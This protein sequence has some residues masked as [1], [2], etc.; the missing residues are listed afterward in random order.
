MVVTLQGDWAMLGLEMTAGSLHLLQDDDNRD[1]FRFILFTT[2]KSQSH[3][4]IKDQF[5]LLQLNQRSI[6]SS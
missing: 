3:S 1:V 2:E 4:F 5:C 6:S